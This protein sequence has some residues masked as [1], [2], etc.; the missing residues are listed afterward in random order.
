MFVLIAKKEKPMYQIEIEYGNHALSVDYDFDIVNDSFDYEYGEVSGVH[1]SED[2]E[3]E[4]LGITVLG[5]VNERDIDVSKLSDEHYS[6][7]EEMVKERI[8]KNRDQDL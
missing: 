8:V 4:I 6:D 3:V 2:I 7:I 1:H 5:L